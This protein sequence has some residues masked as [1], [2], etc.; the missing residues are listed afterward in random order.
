MMRSPSSSAILHRTRACS[1]LEHFAWWSGLALADAR[2]GL[3]MVRS[4]LSDE[5]VPGRPEWLGV[6]GSAAKRTAKEP[7]TAH[8]VPEY[9]ELLIGWRELAVRERTAEMPALH[10]E[11][12]L[13]SSAHHRWLSRWHMAALNH[14]QE[15]DAQNQSRRAAESGSGESTQRGSGQIR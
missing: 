8:L 4:Q 9:D 15:G 14:G 12:H 6:P 5:V 13:L 11:G 3:S 1:L 7:M 10:S 2:K